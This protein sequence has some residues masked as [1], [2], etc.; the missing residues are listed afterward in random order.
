MNTNT[1]LE[2]LNKTLMAEGVPEKE[3]LAR[4]Q[5]LRE[6]IESAEKEVAKLKAKEQAAWIASIIRKNNPEEN[7]LY[8]IL[9]LLLGA[10][11]F[12]QN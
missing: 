1:V 12:Q 10:M 2:N 9:G 6:C 11:T 3:R 7:I 4:V 5:T 8:F